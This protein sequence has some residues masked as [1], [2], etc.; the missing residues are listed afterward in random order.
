MKILIGKDTG[1]WE[2]EPM[3]EESHPLRSLKHLVINVGIPPILKRDNTRIQTREKWTSFEHQLY[4]N[5]LMTETKSPWKNK[6]ENSINDLVVTNQRNMYELD[7]LNNQ[8]HWCMKW[9]EA[10]HNVLSIWKLG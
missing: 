7:V 9:C 2:A 6:V 10:A 1:Y 3:N 5:G 8:S 4:I